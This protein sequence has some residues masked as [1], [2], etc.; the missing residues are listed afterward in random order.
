MKQEIINL[1]REGK[2]YNEIVNIVGCSKATISYHAEKI[3]M[4][5][6]TSRKYNW[7]EIQN[8]YDTGV[9]LTACRE[10]FG[11]A[12]ASWD[13]AILRGEII[14]RIYFPLENILENGYRKNIKRRLLREGILIEKCN[15][16]GLNNIWNNKRLVFVLDHING[17]NNDNR[18][19]NLQLLCPNCNSQTDT[20]SGRN[21]K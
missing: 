4:R 18:I 9:T 13:K 16:C 17:I 3:G 6:F 5:K 14:P 15:I 1:L 11:F 8:Y 7:K 12:K 20:F 10:K 21:K 19:D 2:N